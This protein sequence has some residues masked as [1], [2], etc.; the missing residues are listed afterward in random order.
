MKHFNENN[1]ATQSVSQ[2]SPKVIGSKYRQSYH[3]M[4]PA[5]WMNDPN[6]LIYFKNKY[7][8]FYQHNPYKAGFGK[9]HWGH[10][11]STDLLYWE[12]MPVA[13]S[14][15]ESYDDSKDCNRGGCYSG[16]AI[17]KDDILYIFYTACLVINGE[18]RQTICMAYSEDGIKFCKYENNPIIVP[19]DNIDVANF[20][21]PKVWYRDNSYYCLVGTS[22]SGAGTLAMYRSKDLLDWEYVGFPLKRNNELGDMWECPD[23]ITIGDKDVLFFSPIRSNVNQTVALIGSMDYQEMQYNVDTIQPID[24][25]FDFYAPQTVASPTG[26]YYMI[27]WMGSWSWMDWFTGFGPTGTDGWYGTM[28][29]PRKIELSE[30]GILRILPAPFLNDLRKPSWTTEDVVLHDPLCVPIENAK[31]CELQLLLDFSEMGSGEFVLELRHSRTHKTVISI[32]P[33][34]QTVT[35]DRRETD[36]YLTGIRNNTELSQVFN[37]PVLQVGLFRDT[38]SIELHIGDYFWASSLCFCDSD[39]EEI[40]ISSTCS[41]LRM[42]KA[43]GWSLERTI[44]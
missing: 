5:F 20:R 6:G 17:I 41:D 11:V 35:M 42:L 31:C 12:H 37:E 13:L 21:D 4:P 36:E 18:T 25:G 7:H 24:L 1:R 14:P 30:E 32:N 29:I 34:L 43:E 23:I 38:C 40:W 15:S 10:A 33:S 26:E 3:F 39:K 28:S 27:G 19:R 44:R 9:I 22:V 2:A 8:L 16:T